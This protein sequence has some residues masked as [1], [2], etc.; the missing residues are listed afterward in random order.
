MIQPRMAVISRNPSNL[1]L[2][3]WLGNPCRSSFNDVS[4]IE[5]GAEG[6]HHPTIKLRVLV[7][8][9]FRQCFMLRPS[10]SIGAIGRQSVIRVR[11]GDNA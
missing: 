2:Q 3:D 6:L 8:D 1:L 7:S 10:G 4:P 9:Q 5:K 11:D